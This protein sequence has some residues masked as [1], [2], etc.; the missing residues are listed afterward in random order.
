MNRNGFTLVEILVVI[1]IIGVLLGIVTLQFGR[2]N[3]KTNID[4]Q[5]QTIYADLMTVRAQALLQK[6]PR[7]VTFT[8][9]LF[10]VY[11]SSMA[12]G[13]PV[14][15]R[16]LKYPVTPTAL[17]TVVFDN[18]GVTDSTPVFCVSP[19]EDTA[20]YDS[21]VFDQTRIK[22]GKLKKG[23]GCSSGNIDTK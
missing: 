11:S 4:A 3:R 17:T 2:M 22:M 10:S 7:A 16:T 20:A 6:R 15:T 18:M 19:S 21:I 12:S 23:M 13:T 9:T 5:T 1:T 14:S 8:G